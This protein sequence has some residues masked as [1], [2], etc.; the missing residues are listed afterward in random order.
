MKLL[1]PLDLAVVT[2]LPE[3]GTVGR[4]VTLASDGKVYYDNG[5]TWDDLAAVA[6]GNSG[7][8]TL[9]FGPF[10]GSNEASVAVIGQG[11]IQTTS[12]ANAA[13]MAD[14]SADH[15]AGDHAYA[16]GFIGLSCSVPTAGTGFTINARAEQ[17]MQG[18]FKVRWTWN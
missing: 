4:M 1:S 10:P 2:A 7:T 17:K 6:S 3:A 12:A 11:A 18:T 13:F 15:S 8:A 16:A 5:V 9:D 14:A